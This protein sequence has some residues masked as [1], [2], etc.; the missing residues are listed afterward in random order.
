M[1][2]KL[3]WTT[4]CTAVDTRGV[5]SDWCTTTA[6][7]S[8]ITNAI[9]TN[10]EKPER[11]STATDSN[12]AKKSRLKEKKLPK[13]KNI[14]FQPPLTVAIWDDGTK[15]FVKCFGDEEFDPEKGAAMAIAKKFLGNNYHYTDIISPYI[16]RYYKKHPEAKK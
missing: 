12:T 6:S 7:T 11:K 2:M 14:D 15:T 5:C 3:N 10:A 9:T 16:E 1:D 4:D 13:L 8:F